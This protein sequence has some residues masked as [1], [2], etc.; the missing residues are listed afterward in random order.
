VSCPS[1]ITSGFTGY[2]YASDFSGNTSATIVGSIATR[3]G[4]TS[5]S[6]Q[7]SPFIIGAVMPEF[8]LSKLQVCIQPTW[9]NGDWQFGPGYKLKVS[10]YYPFTPFG[11]LLSG[12]QMPIVAASTYEME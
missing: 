7:S 2:Y 4:T 1:S 9:D 12:A 10:V 8:D 3:L 5:S 11:G 6:S